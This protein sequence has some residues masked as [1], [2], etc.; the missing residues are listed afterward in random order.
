MLAV[1]VDFDC[2]INKFFAELRP[3]IPLQ[4][5]SKIFSFFQALLF[6]VDSPLHLTFFTVFFF[7][8][9]SGNVGFTEWQEKRGASGKGEP[10]KDF[11]LLQVLGGYPHSMTE[12]RFI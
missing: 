9:F 3:Q 6:G 12:L 2:H 4:G 10:Q 1:A 11:G 5:L 8:F 7:F